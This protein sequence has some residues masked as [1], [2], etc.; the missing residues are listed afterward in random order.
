M[1]E[2]TAVLKWILIFNFEEIQPLLQPKISQ[3]SKKV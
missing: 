3:L 1:Q 2:F